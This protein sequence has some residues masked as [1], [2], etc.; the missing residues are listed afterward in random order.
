MA[1]SM[2]LQLL[3]ALTTGRVITAVCLFFLGAFIVD[4]TWKPRYPA[5]LPR[6]GYGDGVVGT[7]RNW[8]G[9]VL[10]FN[11]WVAEG[12]ERFSKH[13]QTFVVPSAASR[14]NEIVVP[15]SQTMWLLEMPDRVV[16]T[17]EAHDDVL[18]NKYNFLGVG[19]GYPISVLHKHLA[20]NLIGLI[21]G[22]QEEVHG[23]LDEIFGVDTQDWKSVNLWEAWLGIVPRVTNRVLVGA[24]IC[25]DKKFLERVVLFADQVVMN[26]FILSMFPKI[27]H[28][29]MGRIVTIRNW[30]SWW[31]ASRIALPTIEKRLQ[32][33]MRKHAGE[34][35]FENWAPTEDFI[36]WVIRQSIVDGNTSELD[37]HM[38]SKRLLPLEFAAIHTTVITGHSLLLDLLSSDPSLGYLDNIKEETARVFREEGG[39]WTKDGLS[40]LYKTDSAIR[41]SQ[42]LSNFATS[43]VK[44]KVIAREGI[45]NQ[46][47]G[48]HAPYG[49][50][51][52][53]NLAGVQHDAD[54]YS[55]P[56]NYDAFRYSRVRI[57]YV[58]RPREKKDKEEGLRVAK[59]G[60]VTTSDA[61]LAFGHGRHACPGRFFV[62]HE[63]KMVLAYLLNN[64][65]IRPIPERPKPQWLGQNIIPPLQ[66]KIEVRRRKGTI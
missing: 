50:L 6:I 19:S 41:E 31:K 3:D 1:G 32:D 45:T 5:E 10:Y 56:Y 63:L 47:E 54:L 61:H 22:I 51:F 17:L 38:I 33:M 36:T 64:Y 28:P 12:Y 35:G 29:I 18:F 55:N 66:A 59:L 42:R 62:A 21:P 57:E 58:E 7:M 20:R 15:R 44:R 8:I 65:E 24:S 49:A 14:P 13:N 39:R 11:D 9:Y 26:S 2:I 4:F 60:M 34:P 23:V 48:W 27:I 30:W 25:R 43:L 37:A 40:R 53:L 16:S 46:A 52:M